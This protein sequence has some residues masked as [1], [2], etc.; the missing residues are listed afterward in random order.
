MIF[1]LRHEP[2]EHLGLFAQRLDQTETPFRYFDLS[3][4]TPEQ[5]PA[6][7][8]ASGVIVMGGPQ[9]ANNQDP[10][11]FAELTLIEA[12]LKLGVPILG[13]CLGAQLLAK[14]L[15]ARVYKN[16]VREIGWEQVR[17]RTAASEDPLFGRLASPTTFFQWHSETFDLPSGTEWLAYSDKCRHQAFRYGRSAYGV[18]FHPE[19]TAEIIAD[20]AA[21]PS[22]G[23]EVQAL[24]SAINPCAFDTSAVSRRILDGWLT[25]F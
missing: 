2:L 17:F 18:Q 20:W 7:A 4:E 19:V 13:I 8:E 14:A 1:V 21:D 6:V 23:E 24:A 12:A 3:G 10:G 9:S 5:I 22:G 16:P 25:T 15:G 11:I